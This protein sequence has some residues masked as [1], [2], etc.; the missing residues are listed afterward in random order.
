MAMVKREMKMGLFLLL[1]FFTTIGYSIPSLIFRLDDLQ[2]GWQ[3]NTTW[4]ILDVFAK[5]KIPISVG[6]ITGFG[7]CYQQDLLKRFIETNGNGTSGSTQLLEIASHSVHHSPMTNYG[8]D[9]QLLEAIDSKRTLETLL[10][11]GTIRT[12]IPPTNVW[13]YD[14]IRAIQ[15]A[16]Y[17]II[18]PQCTISQLNHPYLDNMCTVNM[19]NNNNRRPLFFPSIDGIVHVPTGASQANFG[20]GQLITKD[21]L[22]YA[23][24]TDCLTNSI[25][26]IQSQVNGM[27]KYT[28]G[29][30]WSV[31]MMHPQEF[32]ENIT[33][34]E[35]YFIPIFTTAKANYRLVTFSQLVGPIGSR[36]NVTKM[37]SNPSSNPFGNSAASSTRMVA[38]TWMGIMA[39]LTTLDLTMF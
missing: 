18:S 15:I 1:T 38:M 20:N 6:V 13:N 9:G 14:T 29:E 23:S 4:M 10:G 7:D 24:D 2:C 39:I 27:S 8:Y 11:V 25:C 16:G 12:F 33:F 30:S 5:Y 21:Q 3:M 36:P 32:P 19:Y 35:N 22:F 31:I 26:S 17:D 34:I 37:D 28:D